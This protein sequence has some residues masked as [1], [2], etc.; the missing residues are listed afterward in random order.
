M[1]CSLNAFLTKKSHGIISAGERS[2]E[3]CPEVCWQ[4]KRLARGT[5]DEQEQGTGRMP[6]NSRILGRA[7][8]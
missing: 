4:A 3:A 5:R 7:S 1:A 6:E 2:H 8:V